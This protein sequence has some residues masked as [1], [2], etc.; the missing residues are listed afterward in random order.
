VRSAC[1]VPGWWGEGEVK[2]YFDGETQPT[3]C[4][5]GAEDYVGFAWGLS[6]A[7]APQQGCPMCDNNLGLYSLYRWHT[8]DPVC[9]EK[10]IAVTIQQIG[11]GSE[12]AARP[13][14]GNDFIRYPAAGIAIDSDMCYYDRSDDYCSTAYWYQKLPTSPFPSFPTREERLKDLSL[15]A[16]INHKR[17]DGQ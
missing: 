15:E 12:K 4:G 2:F 5:T 3:I 8:H 17:L 9:F 13:I 14:L 7:C 1:L 6:E 10:S 11:Y 16:D